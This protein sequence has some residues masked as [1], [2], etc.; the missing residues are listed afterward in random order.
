MC[1]RATAMAAGG[2]QGGGQA[3]GQAMAAVIGPGAAELQLDGSNGVWL[4]NANEPGQ[5]GISG[6]RPLAI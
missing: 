4:A 2:N 5:V 1:H 3:I 6:L